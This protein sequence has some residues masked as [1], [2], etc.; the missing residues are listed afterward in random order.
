MK[1]KVYLAGGFK[2]DWQERVKTALGPLYSLEVGA[3]GYYEK[4]STS[5]GGRWIQNSTKIVEVEPSSFIFF[6][7]KVKEYRDG[8]RVN[9][10]LEHYVTWDLHHI[11]LSDIVFVYIERTNPGIGSIAELGYARGLGKIIIAVIEKGHEHIEDRYLDFVRPMCDIVF[12]TL[13]EG[14][15]YLHLYKSSK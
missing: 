2:T 5:T 9:L 12:E 7:P 6:D 4:I 1:T 10:E 13:E 14:I 3:S 15:N 8:K 11:K